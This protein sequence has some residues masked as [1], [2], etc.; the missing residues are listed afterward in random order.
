MPFINVLKF[1]FATKK[2][3]NYRTLNVKSSV[4]L[5]A[6]N[7]VPKDFSDF[8]L[9]GLFREIGAYVLV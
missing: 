3:Q 9:K 7:T 5:T 8:Q 1:Q 4:F 2:G 6:W